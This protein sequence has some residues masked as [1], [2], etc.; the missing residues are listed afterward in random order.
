MSGAFFSQSWY[1]VARLKPALGT[2][3]AIDRHR[4]LGHAWYI[5]TDR[6]SGKSHRMTPAA[7]AFVGRLDGRRTVDDAWLEVAALLD[8]HAPTQ[9]DA[10]MLLSQLHSADLLRADVAPNV[11]ELVERG[12]RQS[13][14]LRKQ[15]LMSPTTLRLPLVD[16]DRFLERTLPF[17]R[18]FIGPFG[19]LLWLGAVAYG[20]TLAGE[21]WTALTENLSDRVLSV[22]NLL[23]LLLTY[24][25]VKA[26]HELG[27]AYVAKAFG[28]EVHEIG[29]M[30]LIF[31]PMPYVDASGAAAFRSKYE[32]AAVGAAG[33]L[34]ETFLASLAMVAWTVLEP[35]IERAICFNI[36]LIGGVSTVLVNANPLLKFDGYYILSDLVEI[37]NLAQRAGR[38][39]GDLAD[40]LLFGAKGGRP[41]H[42]LPAEKAVFAVFAPLSFVY[43]L[44]LSAGIAVFVARQYF[45][46][47]V[48]LAL[49]MAVQTLG[50]PLA[51]GVWHLLASPKLRRSR[52]R[53]VGVAAGGLAGL[54]AVLFVLP[55]PSWTT[56][57]GVVWL[58]EQANVRAGA[59]GF[60]KAFAVAADTAVAS[61][62]AL[63]RFEDPVLSSKIA[64]LAWEVREL[65][66]RLAKAKVED[67]TLAQTTGIELESA[68][69]RLARETVRRARMV[70]TSRTEGRFVPAK[71]E[72]DAVGRFFKEGEIVGYVLPARAGV[73]RVVV[74]QDTVDRVRG[75]LRSVELLPVD[76]TRT[77]AF[78]S[79]I[80]RAVPGGQFEL[81]SPALALAAGGAVA[82]DPRDAQNRTALARLFQFDLDLPAAMPDVYFGARVKVKFVL[83]DEPAGLQI[84]RKLRR[85]FLS[86]FDA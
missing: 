66:L 85:L 83:D 47:G 10:V 42:A 71:A 52:G 13:G 38:Y 72:G 15:N 81:P 6:L 61:G 62:A 34:V 19:L 69:G 67:Q 25:L 77:G 36:M 44:L 64:S 30:L 74:P 78:P 32:R 9:D 51:K 3:V 49:W 48:C 23:V 8:E 57:L 26:V 24:P 45:F 63:A 12:R 5:L 86:A 33:I 65:E 29:L 7:Y 56:A 11:P 21:N 14:M 60:L 68:R 76:R 73:V 46:V 31:V 59:D 50:F 79:R 75:R 18:P 84:W 20:L 28:A 41:F 37:P 17:V 58:P 27:H 43:R 54:L 40:R 55:A 53:A 1:R 22:D 80:L 82:T 39:M 35:G 16:P 2:H 70:A 4:Y